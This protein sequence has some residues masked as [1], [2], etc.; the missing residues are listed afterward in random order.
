MF[1]KLG[2]WFSGLSGPKKVAT[3]VVAITTGVGAVVGAIN[4][5]VDL[6]EKLTQRA[7]ATGPLEMADLDFTQ[8]KLEP[9]NVDRS[10]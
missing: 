4:G 7:Q 6:Q 9:S 1:G 8:A 5:L 3:V 2:S 10:T